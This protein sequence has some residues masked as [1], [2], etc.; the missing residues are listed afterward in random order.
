MFS[1][2]CVC[3][4]D[5]IS[6]NS[7]SIHAVSSINRGKEQRRKGEGEREGGRVWES[8]TFIA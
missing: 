6:N 4:I 7:S 1:C 5:H 3:G 2:M 8:I